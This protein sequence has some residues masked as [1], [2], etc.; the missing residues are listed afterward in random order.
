M[1][2]KI[3]I[4]RWQ[5]IL[6]VI[7]KSPERERYGERLNRIVQGSRTHLRVVLQGLV[8]EGLI[9]MKVRKNKKPVILTEKGER[10]AIALMELR[11]EFLYS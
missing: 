1:V 4:P 3:R 10:M 6:L 11:S 9:T 7:Y 8:R 5:H 2:R